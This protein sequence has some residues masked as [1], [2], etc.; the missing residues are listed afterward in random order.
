MVKLEL[1]TDHYYLCYVLRCTWSS[2]ICK[3]DSEQAGEQWLVKTA[4]LQYYYSHNQ[5]QGGIC[6]MKAGHWKLSLL[7]CEAEQKQGE[8]LCFLLC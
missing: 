4:A 1:K 5:G 8:G 3:L 6:H 7:V 2:M